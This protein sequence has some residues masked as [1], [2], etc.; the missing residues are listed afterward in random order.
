MIAVFDLKKL[1]ELLWSFYEIS[2]L[3]ITVFDDRLCELASYPA[4]VAPY[5][6]VIRGSKQGAAAC[7]ACDERACAIAAERRSTYVYRCHAGL[8]EAVTPLFV[9]S[10]P[11]G[12]LL[13]G[14]V[15][16]YDDRA[17][18][19]ERVLRLCAPLRADEA[20]LRAALQE[21]PQV[22]ETYVK[23]AAHILHAVASYLILEK[24]ASVERDQTALRLDAIL[25]SRFTEPLTADD[26]CREL[27][28]GRTLLYKLSR[29]LYGCGT[30]EYMRRLRIDRAKD[31]LRE[32]C[33]IVHTSHACGWSDYNYF[34]TVFSREVGCP[35]HKWLQNKDA[36]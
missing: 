22:S 18:G 15:F 2:H 32:G 9:G 28:I 30:A 1:E 6:R 26:L 20:A 21:A 25:S 36:R 27:H 35:P 10:V 11:V 8:T 7:A 24:M 14:H 3:R 5:C 17:N 31:L 23:S 29:E 33:S 12:F 4:S 34:I 13:F 19:I 16:S